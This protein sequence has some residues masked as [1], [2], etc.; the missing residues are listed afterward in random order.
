[1]PLSLAALQSTPVVKTLQRLHLA[2]AYALL[3]QRDDAAR[4]VALLRRTVPWP[5]ART[6]V[7]GMIDPPA[8]RSRLAEGLVKAG[9]PDHIDE[10]IPG[11]EPSSTGIR[12]DAQHSVT[13]VGAPGIE[14]L[15]TDELRDRLKLDCRCRSC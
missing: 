7:R 11:G 1:M 8:A 2:A 5:S 9:V 6:L 13:P 15:S 10:Q 12:I 4:Q 3:G 14:T